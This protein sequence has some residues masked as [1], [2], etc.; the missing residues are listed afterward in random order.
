MKYVR[1]HPD[2]IAQQFVSASC[3]HKKWARKAG[4]IGGV[5]EKREKMKFFQKN[6]KIFQK[7][8]KKGG[9]KTEKSDIIR[10]KKES[11]LPGKGAEERKR[12]AADRSLSAKRKQD[13][14]KRRTRR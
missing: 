4:K 11:R 3:G 13:E 1:L 8:G 9:D 10:T 5:G 6:R 12:C 2:E 7:G 14:K